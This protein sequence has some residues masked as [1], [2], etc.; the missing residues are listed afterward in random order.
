MADKLTLPKANAKLALAPGKVE[1]AMKAAEATS[2]K[3]YRIPVSALKPIPGFNVRVESPDYIAHRDTLRA[4]ITAN[5]FDQSKPLTGYVADENGENVIYVTDG[6]TRLAAVEAFNEGADKDDQIKVLP[7]IVR[8]PAPSLAELNIALHTGNTGRTLTPF[9]LG[10]V[11]K[12]A[13]AEEGATKKSVAASL[14]ITP[15]YVDDVL[16]LANADG[17]IKQAVASGVV[18]STLAIGLLRKD[19]DTAGEKIEAAVAKAESTGK[20]ATKKLTSVKMKRI[21]AT[22]Q[23]TDEG[24]MKAIVKAAAAAIRDAVPA[25]ASEDDEDIMLA[26]VEGTITIIVEV[27]APEKPKKAAKAKKPAKKA[28]AD[29]KGKKA[30]TEAEAEPTKKGKGKKAK[31]DL[32]IEGSEEVSDDGIDDEVITKMPP[33]DTKSDPDVPNPDDEVD[34]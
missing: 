33:K 18:S 16:L 27:P 4:S 20:K 6:Y 23:V 15:R 5:G 19:A 2:T 22:I 14:A 8:S 13:L 17:K 32:G 26:A 29:A 34:I 3:L 11:V 28:K 31:S 12:R 30:K 9:E 7:V 1:P 10:I 25:N 21:K 24:D